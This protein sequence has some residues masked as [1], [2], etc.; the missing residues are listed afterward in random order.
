MRLKWK[1]PTAKEINCDIDSGEAVH[2]Q[3]LDPPN[4]PLEGNIGSVGLGLVVIDF[5]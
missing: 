2:L 3:I 1:H 4:N 5:S